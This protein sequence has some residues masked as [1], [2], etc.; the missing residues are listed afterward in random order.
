MEELSAQQAT[1]KVVG[2]MNKSFHWIYIPNLY[3]SVCKNLYICVH[4]GIL[5]RWPVGEDGERQL[6]YNVV[7][8]I[9]PAI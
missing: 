8:N 1:P 9:L 3:I 4:K 6:P 5:R 2:G 7:H